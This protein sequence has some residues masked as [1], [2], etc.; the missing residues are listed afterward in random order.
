MAMEATVALRV[1]VGLRLSDCGDA[2]VF[3][4]PDVFDSSEL[5]HADHPG[6]RAAGGDAGGIVA[7]DCLADVL[8]RGDH[9]LFH[10]FHRQTLLQADQ[11]TRFGKG[12]GLVHLGQ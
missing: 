4:V 3:P 10:F 1:P 9:Q 5:L 11:I 12:F 6:D 2:N 8:H 7:A